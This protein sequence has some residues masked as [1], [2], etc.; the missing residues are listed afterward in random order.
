[1]DATVN[2]A[3]NATATATA[4][5]ATAL[6]SISNAIFVL[7]LIVILFLIGL[8][9]VGTMADFNRVKRDWANY[10]CNPL[11][12]PF[13]GFFGENTKTNFE[14]CMGKIFTTHSQS[15]LGSVASIFTKFT[16]ILSSM[17]DSVSSLRNV[18]ASLGGGIN[19]VFQE[20]T[21]RISMFFFRLRLSAIRMK[22][23]FM[24]MYAILFSVMY[25]GLSGISGMS[26]FTNTYLFSFLDTFCFPEETPLIVEGRG[27]TPICEVK[28]GDVLLPGRARVTA[29]FQ[30]EARGQPMVQLG[31]VTVSTNHYVLH[32]GRRI[33]A[34][35]HPHAI[36]LGPWRSE[37]LLYCLNTDTHYIPVEYVTFMDYDET[38]AGDQ[39]TMQ[40]VDRTVNGF[41][42]THD[43]TAIFQE[44]GGAVDSSTVIQTVHGPCEAK[45]IRVGDQLTTGAVVAGTIV[46]EV[47]EGVTLPSGEWVTASTLVW[48]NAENQWVRASVRYPSRVKVHDK[49]IQAISFV[50]TPNSQIELGSGIRI[51]DYM[52]VCSPDAEQYYAKYL[53]MDK[54]LPC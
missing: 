48:D 18:I 14:F 45:K 1:M 21:E 38:S 32:E 15:Y 28:I 26:S 7:I 54:S 31:P 10:R 9:A 17:M 20:F 52:E 4:T 19:V 8:T 12:M 25:M 49:P 50:V 53:A 41:T 30:F 5:A 33:K 39:E 29:T 27:R 35:D 6:W 34:G 42:A 44:Y 24:R 37:K 3:T 46:K 40:W 13:A 36:A 2:G 16:T 11:I 47:T 43:T 22:S 51:R 23:L